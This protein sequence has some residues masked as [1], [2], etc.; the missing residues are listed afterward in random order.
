MPSSGTYGRQAE[1]DYIIQGGSRMLPVEVKSGTA[2]SLKS[3]PL[4][5][6]ESVLVSVSR[7][8]PFRAAGLE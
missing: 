4:Y 1:I 8:A 5:L 3:L 6:A 7:D 2:G